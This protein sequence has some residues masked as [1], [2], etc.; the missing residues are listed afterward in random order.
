M[1]SRRLNPLNWVLLLA[2]L[3]YL[4]VCGYVWA[5]QKSKIYKPGNAI[6]TTPDRHGMKYEQLSIPSGSGSDRGDLN[7]WWIPAERVDAP[8]LLVL[9]GSKNN[10][11]H[12]I[13][14]TQHLHDAGYNLLLPDY[15]GYGK[16]TGGEPSETKLYEDAESAWNFLRKKGQQNPRKAFIY[17]H[18]LGG[19]VAIEL[20]LRHPEAAG[21]IAEGTFTSMHEMAVLEYPWLPVDLLLNQRFDS[22]AKIGELKVPVLFIH[23]TWDN[24]VSYKMSLQLY[25][26]AQ[27]PKSMSLIEGGEHENSSSIGMLEYRAAINEFT[28]FHTTPQP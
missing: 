1:N 22:L 23:G 19:A 15:R 9:H 21:L 25:E 28:K 20:A 12:M 8:T 18:S 4:T 7:A 11:S 2:V 10:I 3:G 17:G 14:H 24:R 5:T 16:S 13:D 26:K 27:Q 6:Q